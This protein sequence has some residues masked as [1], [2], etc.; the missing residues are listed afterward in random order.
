MGIGIELLAVESCVLLG[1]DRSTTVMTRGDYRARR[2]RQCGVKGRRQETT[3]TT[4]G[5]TRSAVRSES[6]HLFVSSDLS[7]SL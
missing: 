2:K 4:S 1:H 6:P 5:G 3:S 7:T